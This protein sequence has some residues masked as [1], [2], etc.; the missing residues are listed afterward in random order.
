MNNII[1]KEKTKVCSQCKRTLPST[2]EYFHKHPI[3]KDGLKPKCKECRRLD[4][5]TYGER[6]RAL[7]KK[8]REEHREE[9]LARKKKYRE[10]NKEKIKIYNKQYKQNNKELEAIH[11][12][13]RR[14]AKAKAFTYYN[15][16]LWNE[17]KE[18]FE[19]CCCYCGEKRKLTQEHFIPVSKGGDMS[20]NNIIPACS[21]CNSSKNNSDF[22]EWYIKQEFYSKA[23]EK[24]ILSY[25]GYKQNIQ[26]LALI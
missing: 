11:K 18:Q 1:V 17:C 7:G 5:K 20:V 4:T 19:L 25:L 15:V 14:S 16:D 6:Q 23:R 22:F 10:E 24:K 3:S 8:Y 26:Q 12:N 21:R 2:T 13:K 9:I